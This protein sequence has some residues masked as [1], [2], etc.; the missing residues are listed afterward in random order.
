MARKTTKA[1]KRRLVITVPVTLLVRI[2]AIV[3]T[4]IELNKIK[5]YKEEEKKLIEELEM[6]KS[7]AESLNIEITKLSSPDYIARYAREKYLYTKD[8]ETVVI[9]DVATKNEKIEEN[10]K[11]MD[12]LTY[13]TITAGIVLFII[14][15][16]IIAI[17]GKNK[18]T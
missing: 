2:F 7:D 8:G 18:T 11:T 9:V 6:L 12:K 4:V 3:T 13:I 1:I 17:K 10:K 5:N 16:T 15:I 14:V